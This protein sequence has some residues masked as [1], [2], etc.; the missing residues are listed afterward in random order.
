M[1]FNDIWVKRMD[2]DFFNLE[3]YWIWYFIYLKFL[4]SES[5][6]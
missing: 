3:E 4:K 6:P 5:L 2:Y 1:N